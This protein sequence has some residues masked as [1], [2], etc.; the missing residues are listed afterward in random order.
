MRGKLV[1]TDLPAQSEPI[2]VEPR[3]YLR[4]NVVA[5]PLVDQWYGWSYLIAPAT[6]AMYLAN[7]QLKIM[8]SFSSFPHVH[9][10]ALKNPQMI[11]GPFINYDPGRASEIKLLF[12]RTR[13]EQAH[14]L[15][16]ADAIKDLNHLLENE[17]RGESLEPL[18]SKIP[19]ALKG[20]VELTYDLNHNP[21]MRFIEGLLYKS[22]YYDQSRQSVALFSINKDGR[23]NALSTPLLEEDHIL[24]LRIPLSEEVFDELFRMKRAAQPL[25]LIADRLN[26]E[27]KDLDLFSSFFTESATDHH[28]RD[29]GQEWR[30][31]YFGHACLLIEAGGISILSDPLISYKVADGIDR[32]TYADLP[33]RVDYVVITHGH[34]DHLSFETLLQ[35]RQKV[36][37]VIVPRNNGGRL[38]DPSLKLVLQNIGFKNVIE[39]DEME[40]IG[41]EG[42]YILGAPFLGEHADL[43]IR[44]KI[45]YLISI[46]GRS[47]L[48]G[49]DSNALE[50]ALYRHLHDLVK[51]IDALFLGMECAGAPLTWLYG[52]L[53]T[54][55]IPRE[56]D[57]S[58]RLN[59]SNYEKGM[60]L[61]SQ[62]RPSRVYVYAMGLEPWLT[63]IT[64]IQFNEQ[65]MPIIESDKLIES[66]RREGITADRLYGKREIF[67]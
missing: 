41:I 3:L 34:Q 13:K 57:Q 55:S 47:A 66:C 26:I 2:I 40:T 20:Y 17:A 43:D 63:F 30:I 48:I 25:R 62:L 31:R 38:A 36:K 32:Y 10:S 7:Y 56:L 52:P 67:L 9:E 5:M 14:L 61:V 21:S 46:N 39:I 15:E 50:P 18:Y 4:Q 29:E 28:E 33:E 53:L 59:G 42:G 23:A 1:K 37:N 27:S 24:R 45:A 60:S 8:Q 44:S 65:S 12:E 22:R 6:A 54:K 51:D 58:R 64:S 49:A 35:L 19:E 16:L 11:G